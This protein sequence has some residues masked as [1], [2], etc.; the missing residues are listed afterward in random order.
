MWPTLVELEG[1]GGIHSYGLWVMTAFCVA[2]LVVHRRASRIGLH[3]DRLLPIYMAAAVGGLLGG[4]LLYAFA[5]EPSRTLSDPASLMSF[6]G[7][8]FY[9]GVIG[10][11]MAVGLLARFQKIPLWPLADV[12]APAVV[13]ALGIGRVGCFFAGCCHGAVAPMHNGE[14]PGFGLLPAGFQGGQ[15]WLSSAFP[16]LTAEFHTGVGRIH[17]LPLYP[18]QIWSALVGVGLGV[19]LLKRW[20]VRRFD[21]QMA[22]LSLM[23]EPVFRFL[24]E[25][26]RADQRGYVFQWDVGADVSSGLPGMAQAGAEVASGVVG[27]TT[28]QFIAS[29]MFILGAV[30]YRACRKQ[31]RTF[32]APMTR[33]PDDELLE[34][35]D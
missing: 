31:G 22:A 28:S 17:D 24:I 34:W 4:R 8:A 7:F 14:L 25:I 33:D 29:G 12:C 21:G 26:F 11:A 9:G 2:F 32:I 3:P 19:W 35:M 30:M 23:L 15:L 13:L 6:A 10:G 1:G 5:V 27:I 16:F 18:T 20:K